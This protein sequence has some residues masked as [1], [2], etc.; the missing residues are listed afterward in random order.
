MAAMAIYD[1]L[2]P[3]TLAAC[4][5]FT[6]SVLTAYGS[7]SDN[8][9]LRLRRIHAASYRAPVHL[10]SQPPCTPTEHM[11]A[12]W[13]LAAMLLAKDHERSCHAYHRIC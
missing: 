10:D 12:C 3:S 2:G 13:H 1:L 11:A 5:H 6:L 8:Y 9:R 7:Q 4:H